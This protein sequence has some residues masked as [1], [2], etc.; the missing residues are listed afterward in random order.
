MLI[1]YLQAL[2]IQGL[3]TPLKWQWSV[4]SKTCVCFI[5]NTILLLLN[6]GEIGKGSKCQGQAASQ[7][8]IQT[9]VPCTL[10]HPN[11]GCNEM[12]PNIASKDF[13]AY[14][15]AIRYLALWIICFDSHCYYLFSWVFL[16]RLCC[17]DAERSESLFLSTLSYSSSRTR[18]L[19][20]PGCCVVCD[21]F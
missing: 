4:W 8:N 1:Q 2:Y 10:P 6:W 3:S 7:N 21:S 17:R 15:S 20:N 11:M 12:K 16:W 19:R 13:F 14:S 18:W 9:D 5:L